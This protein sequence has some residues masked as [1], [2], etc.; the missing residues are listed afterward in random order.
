MR[1]KA[2]HRLDGYDKTKLIAWIVTGVLVLVGGV[3][4]AV[5]GA[6]GEASGGGASRAGVVDGLEKMC[7]IDCLQAG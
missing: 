6:S 2:G 3:S 1:D 7:V 4:G 5:N